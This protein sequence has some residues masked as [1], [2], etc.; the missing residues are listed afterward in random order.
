M[1]RT[2][3]RHARLP[4]AATACWRWWWPLWQNTATLLRAARITQRCFWRFSCTFFCIGPRQTGHDVVSCDV[5]RQANV[6]DVFQKHFV[7]ATNVARVAKRV[8]FWETVV[9]QQ[10]CHHNVV[11]VFPAPERRSSRFHERALALR[12]IN[13]P[14]PTIVRTHALSWA[15]DRVPMKVLDIW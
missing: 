7:S 12:S 11:V 2:F 13:V 3:W 14:L 9:T 6:S 10:C 15:F 8:N 5:A 4:I 1:I